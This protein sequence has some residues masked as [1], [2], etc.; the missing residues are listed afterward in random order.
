MRACQ[1]AGFLIDSYFM[2]VEHERI[3]GVLTLAGGV[4]F[5]TS[6]FA[7]AQ[8]SIGEVVARSSVVEETG[9][10]ESGTSGAAGSS[11]AP[12]IHVTARVF[13]KNP[14]GSE[15][16]VFSPS[17]LTA[18]GT[19]SSLEQAVELPYPTEYE[20]AQ[21]G[22]DIAPRIIGAVRAG[23]SEDT[24][25][26]LTSVVDIPSRMVMP[27]QP[28]KFETRDIGLKLKVKP[29]MR[30]NG[31]LQV[32]CVYSE[33][34][35]N[36]LADY[37]Q[38]IQHRRVGGLG[39]SHDTEISKNQILMPVFQT[40]KK[41]FSLAT[42]KSYTLAASSGDNSDLR[43]AENLDLSEVNSG[44]PEMRIEVSAKKKAPI[45]LPAAKRGAE[46][47][48]YVTVRVVEVHE[49][50]SLTN[51][52]DTLRE[53]KQ[54]TDPQF[55]VMIRSLNE[56]KG[57]DLLSAPSI[58]MRSGQEGKIEVGRELVFPMAYDP[59]AIPDLVEPDPGVFPVTPAKPMKFARTQ[60]GIQ[61]E[62]KPRVYGNR[63]IEMEVQPMFTEFL[64]FL[65]YGDPIL[66]LE[67]G[68]LGKPK[69]I[70]M[71]ENR[72]EVPVFKHQ[73]MKTTVRIPDGETA[74]FGGFVSTETQQVEDKVPVIGDLPW[75]GRM[76]REE[77]ELTIR[78]QI[79]FFVRAQLMDP[80]GAPIAKR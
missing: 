42:G 71:T 66:H 44:L 40:R 31:S 48:I 25:D 28:V 73:R 14:D 61:V 22:R 18:T 62:M 64:R 13:A 41:S 16:L 17:F 49:E 80:A 19:W 70:V 52:H 75:I 43:F 53:A 79:Y 55:Q 63:V 4:F 60:T 9:E 23:D 35:L 7:H 6:L 57:V 67:E 72:M 50:A 56:E 11:K 12:M 78:K 74:V 21:V 8:E 3:P 47:Q 65:N 26:N 46:P 33:T 69:P 59:A 77:T 24:I 27:V 39:K 32:E 30:S 76:A 29:T 45:S 51:I 68:P 34:S 2:K 36:G 15:T 1:K 58:M 5:L 54:L 37:S 20:P 38:S 10:S